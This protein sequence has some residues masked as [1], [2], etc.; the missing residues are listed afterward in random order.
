[1]N[2]FLPKPIKLPMLRE[3][4]IKALNSVTTEKSL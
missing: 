2:D 1:M 4:A 3:I